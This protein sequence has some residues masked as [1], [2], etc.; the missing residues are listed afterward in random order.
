MGHDQRVSPQLI[1]EVAPGRHLLGVH[2]ARQHS[3]ESFLEAGRPAAA[4]FPADS[5]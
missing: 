1:E 4:P 5:R 3:S 2:D